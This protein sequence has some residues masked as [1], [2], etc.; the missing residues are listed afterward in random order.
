LASNNL[1][2]KITNSI[3]WGY[4][5]DEMT[6]DKVTQSAWSISDENN[7]FKSKN[8]NNHWNKTSNIFNRDPLFENISNGDYQ[9]KSN[10]PAISS[11]NISTASLVD[12]LGKQRKSAPDLGAYENF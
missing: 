9:L 5:I 10:S 2:L 3:V 1:D 11:A 4:K 7:Y 12:I 6:T 8:E